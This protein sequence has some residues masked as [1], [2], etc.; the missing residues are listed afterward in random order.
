ML[1]PGGKVIIGVPF[2]YWLHEEPF[3]FYRYTEH[4]L[5]RYCERHNLRI[6]SLESSGGLPDI[7]L[8]MVAKASQFLPNPLARPFGLL[9]DL[10]TRLLCNTKLYK[11]LARRTAKKFPL[12]Y[13]VVARLAE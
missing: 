2:F 13:L 3:D 8:D 1:R 7:M 10:T 9:H 11:R 5:R 6:L 12:G 4:A